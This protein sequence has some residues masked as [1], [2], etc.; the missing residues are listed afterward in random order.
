VIVTKKKHKPD[1]EGAANPV[2]DPRIAA[3]VRRFAAEQEA[4]MGP[5]ELQA[6]A[7][8]RQKR[9]NKQRRAQERKGK[10]KKSS[11]ADTEQPEMRSADPRI[12]E[13]VRRFTEAQQQRIAEDDERNPVLPSLRADVNRA[14]RIV[15]DRYFTKNGLRQLAYYREAWYSYY[16]ALWSERTPDDIDQF[17]YS[18]LLHCRVVDA[19]G[20][21]Q[22]FNPTSGAVREIMYQ[23]KGM[24]GIPSHYRVPCEFRDGKWVE[25]DA[26][27]KLVCR[28]VLVDMKTGR[29]YSNHSMFIPN[30]ATWEHDAAAKDCPLWMTF[31]HQLF[32]DKADE[33][34]MLQEFFGYTLA[35]D[36]W[37]QKG[38]I[39]VG[40]KRAGKG[41]IGHVLS[42]L[43]GKSMVATPA[44]HAIGTRFGLEN[45]IDKRLCLV[46]DAR[47]SSRQDIFAVIETLLRIIGGDD[48]SVD[49]KNKSMRDV[50]LG[51][52]IMLLSNEMPHLPDNS[53]AIHHRFMILQ[54]E[55]SFLGHEDVHLL[56]KLQSEL[57]AIANWA[58]EGYRRLVGK[59]ANDFKFT[60]PQSSRDARD[61]WRVETNPLKQF[62][63]GYCE[64]R[65]ELVADPSA[66]TEKYNI[67]REKNGMAASVASNHV[68]KEL[69]AMLEDGFQSRW[70]GSK[71][72]WKGI[73]LSKR[74]KK[75]KRPF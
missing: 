31:L 22:P 54:L 3:E 48:V 73:K 9:M 55:K 61:E 29:T 36:T 62:V 59:Q 38:L 43:L 8:A 10:R 2:A 26:R 17:I 45:L 5:T 4:A 27:G 57:P 1:L 65:P 70:V 23:I 21:I 44:L 58:I 64:V 50:N 68:S 71:R 19:D 18:H 39:I 24:V 66:I 12:A 6:V 72:C 46:S 20:E 41:T 15:L 53:D 75:L 13:E 69:K 30:G 63:V 34:A 52:R 25:V 42:N 35:G 37:A 74:G 33:I 40:P 11:E 60:E 7:E 51:T 28:G 16:R 56:D 49:R 67:W 32:G 47:L 14:A